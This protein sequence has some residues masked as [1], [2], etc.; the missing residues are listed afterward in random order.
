MAPKKQHPTIEDLLALR[1]LTDPQL[2]PD[3]SRVAFVVAEAD[4]ASGETAHHLWIVS[5]DGGQARA[6]TFGSA[7][8]REPRWSPDGQRLA[9]VADAAE[10]G[11]GDERKGQIWLLPMDGGQ[12][13]QL[14]QV[15]A[16]VQGIEWSPDGKALLFLAAEMPGDEEQALREQGGIRLVHQFAKMVQIGSVQVGGD[17]RCRQ[18]TR[19]RSSKAMARWSPD[20]QRIVFERRATATSNHS[21]MASLWVMDADG[22][23]KKKL[24]QGKGGDT[25]PVWSPDGSQ[26]AFLHRRQ[27]AYRYIDELALLTLK[28]GEMRILTPKLDR[29]VLDICWSA[30]G[31]RILFPLQDGVRQNLHAVTAHGGRIHQLTEGDRVVSAPSLAADAKQM[32]FLSGSPTYPNRIHIAATD[33]TEDKVLADLN[34]QLKH[35]RLRRTRVVQWTAADGRRI[36]GLLTLPSGVSRGRAV[37]TVVVPHGGPAGCSTCSFGAAAQALVGSGYAVF[38]PNFRGSAGYGQAFLLANEDDFGGGDFGDV[39]AG[40]DMLIDRGIADAQRLAVMGYSY[41]GYMA[42]WAIGHTDRFKAAVVGAGV[43]N[44]QSFFGTTDIQW[45][46]RL[47]QRGAPW[48]CPQSYAE[49][50]PITYAASMRTPTLIYHGD[51]DRRVPMEQSEQL[52]VA[53]REQNVEVEF[54]RYPRAGHGLEEYWHKLDS[55]QRILRFLDRHVRKA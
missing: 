16:G 27:A 10:T 40:V 48:Q 45:F 20:C 9:F 49:Q 3:G 6:L 7:C 36:E 51:E 4:A 47:Y 28:S 29:A 52:Y 38:A 15:A 37:P 5:T 25:R 34:P 23:D 13:E 41:G 43:T 8:H 18:L 1:Q 53:L 21:Y 55:L 19:D 22:K 12:A 14:T 42:S 32:V 44:L 54:V 31:K 17:R 39:M 26:I 33:G 30:D 35:L 46:T 24:S 11:A 2:S 50:S